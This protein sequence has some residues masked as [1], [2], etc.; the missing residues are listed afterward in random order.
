MYRWYRD[1]AKCYVYLSDI[2]TILNGNQSSSPSAL[3]WEPAFSASRWFTRGWTLQE[4]LAPASV[5]FFS[6]D[7]RRIGDKRSLEQ[8]IHRIT[9]IAIPALHGTPLSEFS[10][11][12]RFKWAETRKT[13]REEDW[14]YSL[15]GIF[16]IS[17][18][19]SYGEGRE[20]AVARLKR[21]IDEDQ[22]QDAHHRPAGTSYMP[23]LMF[24]MLMLTKLRSQL[25]LY[26]L[27][28]TTDLSAA[29]LS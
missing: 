10:V 2:L 20:K 12:E 8:Q 27:N 26:H 4:L 7:G 3:L 6:Q 19:L 22:K 25:G 24:C 1:A 11:E 21:M 5:E 29:S 9:G 14:A 16:D 13:T 28:K 15:L 18:W 17:M 23:P